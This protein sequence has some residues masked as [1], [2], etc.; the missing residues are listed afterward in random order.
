MKALLLRTLVL[1]LPLALAACGSAATA[2]L[3][4]SPAQPSRAEK[5]EAAQELHRI[6]LSHY[7]TGDSLRAEEYLA[8]ALEAGGSANAILPDL[9]RAS[10]GGRRYQAAIRYFEDYRKELGRRERGEL[11]M[12][13][14][15]LYLGVEQPELARGA[16]EKSLEIQPQNAK[17]RLLLGQLLH[18]DLQDY[19][20]SDQHFR[21][22][23]ALE[24]EG[25]GAAIARAG[26]MKQT[27]EPA[28]PKASG[29]RKQALPRRTV[30]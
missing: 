15:V 3:A 19:G 30:R 9:M 21:A 4:Q 24:P 14:G 10:I 27:S 25:E 5:K 13:A 17:A 2:P 23:L 18:D 6:G 11:E 20:A 26:L 1:A 29:K 22:Y 8:S 12:V 28:A 16:F 7:R